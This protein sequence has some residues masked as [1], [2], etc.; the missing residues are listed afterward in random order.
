MFSCDTYKEAEFTLEQVTKVQKSSRDSS[1]VSLTSA[2]QG[3]GGHC[4]D[5]AALLPGKRPCT[6]CIVG[7]VDPRAEYLAPNEIR[8]ADRPARS[9]SLYRLRYPGPPS[10]VYGTSKCFECLIYYPVSLVL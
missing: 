4:H 9:K 3:V 10:D 7:W 1:T 6:H 2:V 8:S 5:P